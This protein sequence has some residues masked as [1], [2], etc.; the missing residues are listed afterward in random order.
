MGLCRVEGR[1]KP[2]FAAGP[3]VEEWGH[4]PRGAPLVEREDCS[5]GRGHPV[6]KQAVGLAADP[7]MAWGW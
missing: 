4:P 7:L 5:V 2:L 3:A 6:M 1:Q